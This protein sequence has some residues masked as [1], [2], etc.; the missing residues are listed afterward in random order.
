MLSADGDDDMGRSAE[1]K[2]DET[3]ENPEKTA[4]REAELAEKKRLEEQ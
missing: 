2:D 3:S 1:K 4:Q